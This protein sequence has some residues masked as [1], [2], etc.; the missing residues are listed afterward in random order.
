MKRHAVLLLLLCLGVYAVFTHG[1]I[2]SPDSEVAF[3]TAE[4]LAHKGT[5][6]ADGYLD[7]WPDFGF[8]R[9]KDGRLYS[10]YQPLQPLL[11]APLVRLAEPLSRSERL[12]R[13]LSPVPG[14][15]YVTWSPAVVMGVAPSEPAPHV[16]RFLVMS[17]GVL[18]SALQVLVFFVLVV[19]LTGSIRSAWLAS[20]LFAFCT[21]NLSYAGTLFKEPLVG[22]LTLGAFVV[23][24]PVRGTTRVEGGA[25][26]LPL[27]GF[28]AGLGL[29]TH[30]QG[31]LFI[32]FIG[33]LAAVYGYRD[34]GWKGFFRYAVLWGTG[35]LPVLALLGW[36][37]VARFGHV[38][39]TGFRASAAEM[40]EQRFQSPITGLSGLLFSAG[41]GLLFYSPVAVIGALLWRKLHRER[42][43]E[44]TVWAL[45]A[46]S[47]ILFLAS[48]RD[49][50]GGFCLG[51]RY[52]LNLFP[53]L[54]MPLALEMEHMIATE[55]RRVALFV[56]TW[57][58]LC[59]QVY[60]ATGEIFAYLYR[61]KWIGLRSGFDVFKDDFLY[62]SWKV[63]PLTYFY[64]AIRGPFLLRRV[65]FGN[66][67]LLV[68]LCALALLLL[69]LG[70]RRGLP[71]LSV[72]QGRAPGPPQPSPAP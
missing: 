70:F 28:L 50:H 24:M 39:D 48:F 30:L 4:S 40:Q 31:A 7:Q 66:W 59:Q 46:L 36:H 52:L 67:P 16:L 1:G 20:I 38:L 11:M 57:L 65:P 72:S 53:Y 29:A 3:R 64:N 9:G 10:R 14:S 58:A 51:P 45:M 71:P 18:V 8:A 61:I 60:F 62:F 12:Q 13:V 35:M 43:V 19:K 2:R 41:K 49:W 63:S 55:R 17:L 23:L 42:P 27:S 34:G 37:N 22:L 56:V 54:L 26:R 15:H 25:W 68:L 32:P 5:F 21:M 47:R 6:A 44:S 33:L 69:L